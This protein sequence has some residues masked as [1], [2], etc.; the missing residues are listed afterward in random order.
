MKKA[1]I[2]SNETVLTGYRVAQVEPKNTF[3]V[4]KELF[5]IDCNDDVVADLFWYDPTDKSIKS[6][7][8]P[9]PPESKPTGG[10]TGVQEF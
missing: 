6:I 8:K 7:P 1:L 5:W 2:S 9:T 3:P 4:A 10:S